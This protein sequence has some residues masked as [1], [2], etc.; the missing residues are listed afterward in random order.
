VWRFAGAS[1]LFASLTLPLFYL[2]YRK[3]IVTHR[4]AEGQ[5]VPWWVW[6]FPPAYVILPWLLGWMVGSAV[7]K[8]RPWV[9]VLTGPA[10][11]PRAWD[12]LFTTPELNGWLLL[13]L[14]DNTWIAGFWGAE[15]TEGGTALRSYAS[16]YPESQEFYFSDTG[17]V[18]ADGEVD[19]D[20]DGRPVPTGLGVLVRWDE[21]AY[22]YFSEG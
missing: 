10:P 16:G 12:H 4:L 9:E 19:V 8:R 13:R 20:A 7:R 18:T 6:L 1:A 17:E 22:A 21:V 15:D 5:A 3:L 11:S 2:G 14:K